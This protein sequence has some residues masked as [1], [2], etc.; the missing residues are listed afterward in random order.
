MLVNRVMRLNNNPNARGFIVRVMEETGRD[1][2][3]GIIKFKT[4]ASET[5]GT[6]K[7]ADAVYD[8]LRAEYDA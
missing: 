5:A 2:A 7:K 4:I 3:L 6:R 8:R 1:N